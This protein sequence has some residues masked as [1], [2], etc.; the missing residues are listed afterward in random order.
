[1]I[2]ELVVSALVFLVYIVFTGSAT[3]YDLATGAAVSAAV[4][5]LAARHLVR[6]ERKLLQPRRLL[7]FIYYMLKYMTVIEFKAHMD[8]VKRVFNMK[9]RPGIVRVPVQ[10][11]TAYGRLLVAISITNTPGTVVVDDKGGYFYVNWIDVATTE[12][13]GARQAIS[14]EF[15]DYAGKIF[16]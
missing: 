7:T 11:K 16:E 9:L 13:A 15:E 8:V 6:D 5:A 3:P 1:M 4:G 12:P 10:P 14:L 2:R